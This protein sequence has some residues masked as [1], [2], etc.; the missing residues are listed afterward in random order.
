MDSGEGSVSCDIRN[1]ENDGVRAIGYVNDREVRLYSRN[2]NEVTSHY[3]ELQE[4]ARLFDGRKAI[5]DGEIVALEAGR[6]PSF[7]RLQS[8]MH[9]TRPS[10]NLIESISVDYFLFD[11]LRLEDA[12]LIPLP[13]ATRRDVGR[14]PSCR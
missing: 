6:R 10:R 11:L 7:S 13:Y 8:R 1:L 12:D 5:V 3:P 14:A 9:V 2:G 4:L